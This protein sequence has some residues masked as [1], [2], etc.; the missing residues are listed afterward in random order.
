MNKVEYENISAFHPGYYISDLIKDLE[1]TQEEFAIRLNIT[2]KNLSELVN[3]KAS[4]SDNIAKNLSLM[5]GTSV[6]VWLEL[7]NKY[8][9]KIIEMKALQA[10]RDEEIELAHVDYSYF[11]RLGVVEYTKDKKQQITSLF[12]FFSISS[13][14]VFKKTDFLVQYRKTQCVDEKVILN[15]NAW[16]QTVISIGKSRETQPFSEKKTREY[17]PQIKELTLNN[18]SD[19]I[20][21]LSRILSECGVSFVLI[22][23][24]KNSGVYGATKWI[25][26][27]KVILGMTNRG[28]Y[29]DIFWF[30]LF[31]EL[32]HVFQKKI[33]KTLVDFGA[34]DLSE[35]YEKEADQFAKDFLV[36]PKEYES[37]ISRSIF[38]EQDI[39]DFANSIN[40]H[41]GIV[42]GRLQKEER[43]PYSHQ[44]KLRQKID[45][46][47]WDILPTSTTRMRKATSIIDD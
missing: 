1:M 29:A 16:V 33:T 24:L 10:Q 32:G 11:C 41:P 7:Q 4:I 15:S 12:K 19:F 23:S 26:K 47:D 14:S 20:P 8:N 22:P 43:L 13:F 46:M 28:K 6:D 2:P 9:Q 3:G 30:S 35:D 25:S 36:P 5:L 27:E 37:F 18:P 34:G 42:V 31:H 17:L 39:R 40:I 45:T 44:N 38:T 21:K